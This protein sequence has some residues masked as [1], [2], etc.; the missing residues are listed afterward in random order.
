MTGHLLWRGQCSWYCF[1]C[2]WGK[3]LY[4]YVF[5]LG[6]WAVLRLNAGHS[7]NMILLTQPLL[8]Y[9]HWI[10]I[11]LLGG[12]V[13]GGLEN[14]QRV[15]RRVWR[16]LGVLGWSESLLA[17]ADLL[18]LLIGWCLIYTWS[19]LL[20]LHRIIDTNKP[21]IKSLWSFWTIADLFTHFHKGIVL[22]WLL[23]NYVL[24]LVLIQIG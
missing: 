23:S 10:D 2:L 24:N 14:M 8:Q 20:T 18:Y 9:F 11:L 5:C 4:T 1:Y 3:W 13:L 15:C 17:L 21:M 7:G 12:R 22:Y 19:E 6:E 16:D